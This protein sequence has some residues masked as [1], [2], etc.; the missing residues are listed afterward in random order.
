MLIILLWWI[1]GFLLSK[2]MLE[3]EHKA[4]GTSFT[5]GDQALSIFFSILS[6]AM[7][8]IILVKTWTLSVSP[9]WSQQVKPT[10]KP[11]STE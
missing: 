6:W 5:R 4:S 7:V 2:W 8:L 10:K 3:V 1:P 11:K 9:Y